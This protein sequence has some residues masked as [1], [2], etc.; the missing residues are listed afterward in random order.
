M[1]I[2]DTIM[3]KRE[4]SMPLL[5]IKSSPFSLWPVT[6]LTD[7]SWLIGSTVYINTKVET[8]AHE[9]KINST[10]EKIMVNNTAV[11]K[12]KDRL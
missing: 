9:N 7:T 2:P 8:T 1:A 5:G 12:A 4:I 10:E 3:G 6:L 11:H